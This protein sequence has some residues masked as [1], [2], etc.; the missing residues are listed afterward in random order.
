M[1]RKPAKAVADSDQPEPAGKSED[2]APTAATSQPMPAKEE[3]APVATA[4]PEALAI[5]AASQVMSVSPPVMREGLAFVG[6]GHSEDSQ[7]WMFK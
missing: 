1:A 2:K 5:P 7:A 3:A 6:V 4:A